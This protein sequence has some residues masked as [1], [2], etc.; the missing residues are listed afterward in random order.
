MHSYRQFSVLNRNQ[1]QISP[2]Q[3]PSLTQIV[4]QN[5]LIPATLPSL[6]QSRSVT[7]FSRVKGKRYTIKA[8]LRRFYRLDWGGWIRVRAARH[9][10]RW[11]KKPNNKYRARQHVLVNGTQSW[12][13]DK[14]V[15]RRWRQPKHYVDDI[16]APYHRRDE[17]FATKKTKIFE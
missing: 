8:V 11:R 7:K 13:L 5:G 15:T 1:L 2:L 3:K 9:K 10:R 14:C 16:Y 12:L 4:Q 6:T 17:Y